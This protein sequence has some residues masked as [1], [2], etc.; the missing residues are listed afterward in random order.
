MVAAKL[1]VGGSVTRTEGVVDSVSFINNDFRFT[2]G[3]QTFEPNQIMEI[4]PTAEKKP[5][6]SDN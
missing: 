4:K 3:D 6:N 1:G 2:I 5:E